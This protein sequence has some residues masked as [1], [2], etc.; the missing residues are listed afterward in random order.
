MKL[1]IPKQDYLKEDFSEPH[2]IQVVKSQIETKILKA[3]RK[4]TCHMQGKSH[5]MAINGIL[6]RNFTGQVG[7]G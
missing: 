4:T 2:Y 6:N 5:H 3:M 1:R 7:M